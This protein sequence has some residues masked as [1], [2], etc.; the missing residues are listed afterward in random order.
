MVR[1][2][3]RDGGLTWSEGQ[4]AKFPNPNSAIEFLKL[5]SGALLL[6]YNDSMTQRTPLTASLSTDGDR[7]Y[8]YRRNI[9]EGR[10]SFA[11]PIGFQAADG[12]IHIVYTSDQRSVINHAVFSEDW[13]KKGE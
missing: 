10:N 7:T 9:A 8:P 1:S 3:S 4:N 13:V 11:Y 12:R 5:A 2:E 6:V